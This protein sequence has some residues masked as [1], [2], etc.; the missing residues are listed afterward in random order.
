MSERQLF[1]NLIRINGVGPKLAL[2]ILSGIAAEDFVRCIH[3]NDAAALVR[4]PG[5]GKKTAE[6]MLVEFGKA[7]YLEKAKQQPDKVKMVLD[8]MKSDGLMPTVNS[9]FNK[10]D[11]PLPLGYCNVGDVIEIEDGYVAFYYGKK[12][13]RTRKT[14]KINVIKKGKKK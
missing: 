11:Q 3:D 8:K 10:L 12:Q 6:R 4:L 13:L 14:S 9:V 2:T 5:I 7:N 1:R